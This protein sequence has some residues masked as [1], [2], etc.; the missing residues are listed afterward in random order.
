MND[1]VSDVRTAHEEVMERHKTFMRIRGALYL[2]LLLFSVLMILI[3]I[4]T[5][6]GS[7]PDVP[8]DIEMPGHLVFPLSVMTVFSAGLLIT[9]VMQDRNFARFAALTKDLLSTSYELGQLAEREE[10][11]GAK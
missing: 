2:M 9:S 10:H 3:S 8:A 4:L 5:T 11:K 7:M 1:L 6:S